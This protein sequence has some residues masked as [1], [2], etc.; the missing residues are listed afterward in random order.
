M[1]CKQCGAE[2]PDTAKFCLQ[3]GTPVEPESSEPAPPNPPP[4]PSPSSQAPLPELDFV[5]PAMTG[6]MLLGLLSSIPIINTGNCLCCMWVLLGGGVAA[7]LLTRQRSLGSITYGDGAFA[8]VLS[9]SFGAVIGTMVQMAVH[10][11]SAR[12]MESQQQQM[13]NILNRIG[14][15]SPMRDWVLRVASGEISTFTVVFTFVSNLIAYSLFAMI[16]GILA[17]AILRKREERERRG[18][19]D[20]PLVP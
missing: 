2:L 4:A 16:G 5:Q 11:L 13:E 12:F 3:C 10:A 20:R 6:G 18:Q 19:G 17:L 14:M 7:V 1:Q 8:G 15:E 9:G